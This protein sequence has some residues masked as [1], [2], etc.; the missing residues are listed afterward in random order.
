MRMALLSSSVLT[1]WSP[2]AEIVWEGLEWVSLLEE[3]C[4]WEQAGL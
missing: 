4:H 1:P 2:V 3:M